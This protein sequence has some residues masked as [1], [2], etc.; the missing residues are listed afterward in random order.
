LFGIPSFNLPIP[1]AGPL[2]TPEVAIYK[3]DKQ[4]GIAKFGATAYDAK[5][6]HFIAES[7]PPLGRSRLEKQAVLIVSWSHDDVH[8]NGDSDKKQTTTFEP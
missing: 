8:G 5:D 7:T 2:A 4:E 3:S 1:L 6:G